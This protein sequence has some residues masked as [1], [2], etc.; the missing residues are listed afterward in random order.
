[1]DL[2]VF[3]KDKFQQH[4]ISLPISSPALDF[5]CSRKNPVRLQGNRTAHTAT[6]ADIRSAVQCSHG[7]QRDFLEELYEL[8]FEVSIDADDE[9]T[10]MMV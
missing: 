9:D 5:L 10:D 8:S 2:A 4:G 3:I 6:Q 1:M 7:K